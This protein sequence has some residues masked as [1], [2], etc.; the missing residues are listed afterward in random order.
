MTPT[1]LIESIKNSPASAAYIAMV[2]FALVVAYKALDVAL[3][4][5]KRKDKE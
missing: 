5:L 3:Q 2:F 4:A 1:Q